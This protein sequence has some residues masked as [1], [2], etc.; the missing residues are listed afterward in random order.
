M[1]MSELLAHKI[2]NTP[3]EADIADM[4]RVGCT[5]DIELGDG[6]W[7]GNK[8]DA[9]GVMNRLNVHLFQPCWPFIGFPGSP[10]PSQMKSRSSSGAFLP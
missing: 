10:G 1:P 3:D 8:E 6:T 5:C 7:G 9:N 4:V 2:V